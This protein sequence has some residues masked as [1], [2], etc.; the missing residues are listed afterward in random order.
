[1]EDGATP[2][3]SGDVATVQQGNAEGENAQRDGV[4]EETPNAPVATTPPEK[5]EGAKKRI[6]C[7]A[8]KGGKIIIGNGE[9]IQID[10]NGFFEVDEKEAER[11]LSIPGYKEA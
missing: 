4:Q 7:E 1:V 8:L 5:N 10:E 3:A 11:L 2:P 9:V 6:E